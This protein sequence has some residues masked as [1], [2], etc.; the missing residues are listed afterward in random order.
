MICVMLVLLDL[1][2][3]DFWNA[4][5]EISFGRVT[6]LLLDRMGS[7]RVRPYI[8]PCGFRRVC[9]EPPLTVDITGHV[10]LSISL[11]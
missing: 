5:P 4:P 11:V 1:V 10:G 3:D 2:F 6:P 8:S 9:R 7:G